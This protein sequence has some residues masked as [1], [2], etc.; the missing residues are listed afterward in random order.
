M[1]EGDSAK[2]DTAGIVRTTLLSVPQMIKAMSICKQDNNSLLLFK[3][4]IEGSLLKT[5]EKFLGFP[6]PSL[7]LRHTEI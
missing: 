6:F 2:I 3:K 7:S 5:E 4:E 1:Y